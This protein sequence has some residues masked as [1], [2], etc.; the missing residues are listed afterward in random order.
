[1]T[2]LLINLGKLPEEDGSIIDVAEEVGEEIQ[3]AIEELKEDNDGE[4]EQ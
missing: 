1:M 3:E 2:D 4:R